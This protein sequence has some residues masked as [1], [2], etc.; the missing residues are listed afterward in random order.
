[1]SWILRVKDKFQ[2]AHYL[3]NYN[4]KCEKIHGHTFIVEVA[5]RA[6]RLDQAGIGIDFT[7]IKKTLEEILPD[8]SLL[9]E[10][11]DFNPSAENLSRRFFE[12]L[13]KKYPVQEVTVWESQDA[14]ATFSEDL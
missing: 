2:A 9:N 5:V 3:E 1:M 7:E 8:H 6:D 13:K 12:E 11:Y 10:R 14:S 4:G